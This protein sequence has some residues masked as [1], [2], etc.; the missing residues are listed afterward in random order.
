M[1]IFIYFFKWL[2]VFVTGNYLCDHL[3]G[4]L[5][6]SKFNKNW[7][8]KRNRGQTGTGREE[9]HNGKNWPETDQIILNAV[10]NMRKQHWQ[11][12]VTHNHN[13]P[14]K[15]EWGRDVY[16]PR[17]PGEMSETNLN[18]RTQMRVMK[19]RERERAGS[20]TDVTWVHL[21]LTRYSLRRHN[22]PTLT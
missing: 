16:I 10:E 5:I 22:Y 9:K 13:D 2:H 18:P 7:T 3:N 15:T 21:S 4:L 17:A 14:T 19:V 11:K 6:G 12:N 8:E 20:Q 1:F